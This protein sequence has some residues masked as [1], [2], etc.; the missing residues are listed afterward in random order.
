MNQI[1][2]NSK[3]HSD[4]DFSGIDA[5]NLFLKSLNFQ[6]SVFNGAYFTEVHFTNCNLNHTEFTEARFVNCKFTDCLMDYSDFVYSQIQNCSFENCSFKHVEWRESNFESIK[7]SNAIFHNSTIS[8]CRFKD[9]DFDTN[10][11]ESFCGASKRFNVFSQGKFILPTQKVDFLKTNFGILRE[12][13]ATRFKISPKH[14]SESLLRLSV[15]KFNDAL[16][17][18]SFVSYITDTIQSLIDGHVKNQ[19]Q[20]VKYLILVCKNV[21]DEGLVSIFGLQYLINS[22]NALAKQIRDSQIFMEIVDL[23][24]F[25]KTHQ[26]KT[27]ASYESL[28]NDYDE[29]YG[30]ICRFELSK[31]YSKSDVKKY[32]SMMCDFLNIPLKSIK[33][34]NIK[35]GST[36]FEFVINHSVQLGGLLIFVNF[37]LGQVSKAVKHLKS[38]KKDGKELLG[39]K[40]KKD[41]V[42]KAKEVSSSLSVMPFTIM[43][44]EGNIYYQQINNTVNHYGVDAFK[45]DGLGKVEVTVPYK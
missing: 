1:D 40:A 28:N 18:Q 17:T 45:M 29:F 43:N 26:Y 22:L 9:F 4:L 25:L 41:K 14:N 27:I 31:T 44:N 7:V 16:T 42:E 12:D 30:L 8:L 34:L 3:S 11:S 35:R 5:K 39:L 38:I 32:L 21:I 19:L 33:Q 15:A 13:D 6:E 36:I 20:K 23:I 37:S 24:M 10:S 2:L